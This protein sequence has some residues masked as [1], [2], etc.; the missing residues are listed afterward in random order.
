[1]AQKDLRP[2]N[3]MTVEEQKAITSAGGKASGVAR[4]KR[5]AMREE[6]QLLLALTVPDE[7]AK[8]LIRQFGA[9]KDANVQ[10][11]ILVK[12]CQLAMAGDL[13]ATKF[14]RDT[15]GEKPDDSLNLKGDVQFTFERA[16]DSVTVDDLM[17]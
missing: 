9:E 8:S 6:L 15:I 4:A 17:G 16:P 7:S 3:T 5:K 12:V 14:L 2:F 11:A 10:T 1:M 13:D